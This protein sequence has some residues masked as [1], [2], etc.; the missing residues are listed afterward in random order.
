MARPSREISF[1]KTGDRIGERKG[2][3]G[4]TQEEYRRVNNHPV[5]LQQYIQVI[6]ILDRSEVVG[7]KGLR[8]V[9]VF[10]QG[11]ALSKHA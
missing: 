5:V 6:A 9:E 11:R 7:L 1:P 2:R 4:K 10:M 3:G 8:D